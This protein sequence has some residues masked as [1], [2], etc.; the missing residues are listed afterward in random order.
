[1]EPGLGNRMHTHHSPI[2][3][4]SKHR[5]KR[6]IPQDEQELINDM[7]DSQAQQSPKKFIFCNMKQRKKQLNN[8]ENSIMEKTM[9]KT[10]KM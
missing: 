8:V 1:M 6:G 9:M 3:G 4:P 10:L 5:N 7:A 2:N